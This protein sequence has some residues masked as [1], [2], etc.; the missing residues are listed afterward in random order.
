MYFLKRRAQTRLEWVLNPMTAV[1]MGRGEGVQIKPQEFKVDNPW[2]DG[3]KGSWQ[4]D[5]PW[6]AK[7]CSKPPEVKRDQEGPSAKA[8]RE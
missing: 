8:F 5:S 2:D 1:L 4:S 6:N 3:D 7:S